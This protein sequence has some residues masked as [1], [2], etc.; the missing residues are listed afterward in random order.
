MRTDEELLKMAEA[1]NQWQMTDEE[2]EH[3]HQLPQFQDAIDAAC[4]DEEVIDA[5][6]ELLEADEVSDAHDPVCHDWPD[7]ILH[8]EGLLGEVA[9]WI[10]DQSGMS[11]P[12][13]ALAAALTACGA[14]LGRGVQDYTGQRTNIYSLAVGATSAGKNDPLKAIPILLNA[15]GRGRLLTGELTSDA[16][17]E[18]ELL[19][20]P[21]KCLMLDEAGH[22]LGSLKST[23]QNN[24]HL[25]TVMPML[26]KA[27]SAANG[28]LL[29]KSRA[30]D[31]NGKMRPTRQI[32]EPCVSLYATSAPDVLF[33][34]MTDDDM[35]DGSIPRFV[36]FIS[37]KRPKFQ[38]K[39]AAAIPERL[40]TDLNN[41]LILLDL[42]MAKYA[43]D[44]KDENYPKPILIPESDDARGVFARFMEM[45]Y[46]MMCAADKGDPPLYLYGK[47]GENARRVA[48]IVAALRNPSAPVV[49]EYAA[50]YATE[51][52]RLSV[53][54][55]VEY[56]RQNVANS[57]DERDRQSV[58]RA[59]HRAGGSGLSKSALTRMTRAIRR[60]DR[61][62]YILDLIDERTIQEFRVRPKNGGKSETWYRYLR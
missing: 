18:S 34:S 7:E 12:K 31:T 43:S 26:T 29:G 46:S 23:G 9:A 48:L 24:G 15:L 37:E 20:F 5:D 14:M 1:G 61:D 8:P 60:S 19:L 10:Q 47:V 42:P 52:V 13:F 53:S 59:I 25:K 39:T 16:A 62:D 30:P 57:K 2:R 45:Q 58:A 17:L 3:L 55:M 36:S 41:A 4:D 44:V 50:R 40:R 6:D 54:E 38:P 27:W 49:D 51:L 32:V 56:V 33:A 21:V 11:Q 28:V 22:Y 35:K